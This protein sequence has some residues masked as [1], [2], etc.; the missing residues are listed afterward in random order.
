MINIELRNVPMT[1][2]NSKDTEV[3]NPQHTTYVLD[4]SL[5]FKEQD[6]FKKSKK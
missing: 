6:S 1:N 3:I 5:L 2:L 4:K